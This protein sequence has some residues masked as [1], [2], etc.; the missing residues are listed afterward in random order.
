MAV[1]SGIEIERNWLIKEL[2]DLK[3]FNVQKVL[4][5][6]QD[7]VMIDGQGEL[8]IRKCLINGAT[9]YDMAVKIGNGV[10]RTEVNKNLNSDEYKQLKVHSKGGLI[11]T[12]IVIADNCCIQLYSG[13]LK[14]LNM[15][16]V[17][18]PNMEA[19][20]SFI[21][22]HWFGKDVSTDVRYR[23]KSLALNGMPK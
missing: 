1:D 23:A 9:S 11:K 13:N 21:P 17:E 18:F 10:V 20:K 7:Y 19:A 3:E 12:I 15:V 22:P 2:P 5:V 16:E 4:K 8:R 14:G 6:A